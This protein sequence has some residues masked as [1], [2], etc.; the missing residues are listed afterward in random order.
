[1]NI[2]H[3]LEEEMVSTCDRDHYWGTFK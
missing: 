1:M 2:D 3:I